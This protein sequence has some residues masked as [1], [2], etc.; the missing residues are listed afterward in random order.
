MLKPA[1]LLDSMWSTPLMADTT[2]SMGVV[3][4]PRMVS[5]LAPV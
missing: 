1:R 4:K 3:R 5:A 2:R